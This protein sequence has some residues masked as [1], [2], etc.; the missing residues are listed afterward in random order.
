MEAVDAVARSLIGSGIVDERVERFVQV[1][2]LH[3]AVVGTR[4]Q[5][6][7]ALR[8][9]ACCGSE[10]RPDGW[11]AAGAGRRAGGIAVERIERRSARRHPGRA[12]L[13]RRL[14]NEWCSGR[15]P[16]DGNDSAA[17][18]R[19]AAGRERGDAEERECEECVAHDVIL[20]LSGAITVCRSREKRINRKR[21][22]CSHFRVSPGRDSADADICIIGAALNDYRYRLRAVL[23]VQGK[24]FDARRA[25]RNDAGDGAP[26]GIVHEV[27]GAGVCMK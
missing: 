23:V 1:D 20:H 12:S 11:A 25:W 22:G 4:D 21:N 24:N 3:R 15:L 19:A 17:G 27:V 5:R 6:E 8:R 26:V 13:H 2:P 10:R 7:V 9:R 14:R 16:A 18:A